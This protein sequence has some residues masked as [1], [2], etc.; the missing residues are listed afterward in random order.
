MKFKSWLSESDE[1]EERTAAFEAW[2][3]AMT[4]LVAKYGTN[5]HPD[6]VEHTRRFYLSAPI[7][8]VRQEA[9]ALPRRLRSQEE[10]LR[11]EK[12]RRDAEAAKFLKSRRAPA[13]VRGY[14]E[15]DSSMERVVC[16]AGDPGF[17]KAGMTAYPMEGVD[18]KLKG[19]YGVHVGGGWLGIL[20]RDGYC[21]NDA[22]L[23]TI[24]CDEMNEDGIAV[25]QM[26]DPHVSYRD[27]STPDSWIIFS[28]KRVIPAKYIELNKVIP[29]K[30]VREA[31]PPH[32]ME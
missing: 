7:E 21:D 20:K 9:A 26:E 24:R 4:G 29:E 22:Y 18:P 15:A 30:K 12:V 25:Y 13:A 1:T 6:Y 31:P 8:E 28:K 3:E 27:A 5:M 32:G 23:Y 11:R 14:D 16:S 19:Y 10:D 17:D 2:R